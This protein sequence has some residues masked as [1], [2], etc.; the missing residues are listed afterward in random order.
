MAREGKTF[1][2]HSCGGWRDGHP[3]TGGWL[4]GGSRECAAAFEA[5]EAQ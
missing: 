5:V 1:A 4:L 3:R 2:G